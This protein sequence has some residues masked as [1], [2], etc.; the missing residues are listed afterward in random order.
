MRD[1]LLEIGVEE[2]PSAYISKSIDELKAIAAQKLSNARLSYKKIKTFGSPRRLTLLVEQLEEQQPDATIE[3]RGPKKSIAF[4]PEGNPTKA[5]LGFARSQG[6]NYKELE[7]REVAGVEYIFIVK[8]EKGSA[9]TTILPSILQDIVNSLTFPKSMRWSYYNTRFARPIRWLLAMFGGELIEFKIENIKSGMRTYG[10]RFLS[11]GPLE[12]NNAQHYFKVLKENYVIWD[13]KERKELIWKQVVDCAQAVGG[14]PQ[15][16]DML[17]EEVSYLVEYPTAFYGNFS[18]SYLDVP[19]EVLTTTMIE[20]QRYFPVFDAAGK[21]MAGFVGVRNGTDYNLDIVRAGN[22]RVLKARLEDA[23]FFWKEDTRKPL[24]SMV[25]GLSHVLFQERLGTVAD[26][27][28]RLSNLAVYIGKV[29]GLSDEETLRRAATLCKADLVSNMV[30]EFPELQGI[31]GRYYA[32]NNGEK[33]EVCEAIFEHYLPR[34]AG[35]V[36]PVTASGI[37]LSLAE[38]LDNLVGCFAIGIKPSGSQ[39]PYALRRQA[40]GI[41]NIILDS[42]RLDLDMSA[43]AGSAYDN[44]SKVKTN[45]TKEETVTQVL[46]FIVQRMRGILLERGYS[47]DVIDAV[48]AVNSYDIK[49]IYSRVAILQELKQSEIFADLMVV[50]NR[51]HNLSQ[52]WENDQV[53][54]EVLKDKSEIN[55]Y[56]EFSFIKEKVYDYIN[57]KDYLTACKVLGGLR[58]RLDDFFNAVMVMADD[59]ELKAA[60]LSLLKAIANT[61]NYIADFSSISV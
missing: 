29:S 40:M 2:I 32:R 31:M 61:C 12:V 11:T 17:L 34:F 10:H 23:W 5:G 44:L 43:L 33:P 24:S 45:I 27:I 25:E 47:H 55:L 22:E 49:D 57:A 56:Y 60:R 3:N 39:D 42:T 38:K 7:V 8:K 4:D 59:Q 30:Y 21:L 46:E 41:V 36:L 35:D 51:C 19:P 14:Y 26:K 20:H 9:S 58:S 28:E 48:L 18:S 6:V 50:Y 53:K 13:Q 16:N 1:L 54:L 37:V 15:K 52:K